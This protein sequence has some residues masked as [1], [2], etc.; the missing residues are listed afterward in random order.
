MDYNLC[1]KFIK[2]KKYMGYKYKTETIVMNEIKKY[3]ENNNIEIITKEVIEN[4]ARINPNL[5]PNTLA[6]NVGIFREFCKYLKMQDV[7]SYQIPKKL[8]PQKARQYV[9]YIFS[10]DEIKLILK[11]IGIVSS[12]PNT[13]YSYIKSQTIPL[14]IRILYQTGM[15]VGEVLNLR[16]NDY[17]TDGYFIIKESKNNEERRIYLPDSLNS[18]VLSYHNKFHQNTINKYFFQLT[19][20]QINIETIERNF[21]ET[22]K[23]SN[24][25]K[26]DKGPRIHDL[27]HT[28]IVRSIEKSFIEGKDFNQFLPYLQVYV[29]HSSIRSLEYYFRLT[30]VMI[31]K[32]NPLIENKLG[33]IIPKVG[34]INE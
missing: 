26:T 15:R 20:S 6:R 32:L 28:F 22:L 13:H 23:L 16:I 12:S 17:N 34:D 29:G 33:N 24:I 9:P 8:Y 3:L 5:K 19:K 11:N 4:Y 31:E 1:N 27:R 2:Y 18:K 30:N 7:E 21:Y 25:V 10:N 14:I